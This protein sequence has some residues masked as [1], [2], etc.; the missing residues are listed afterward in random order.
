MELLIAVAS[1]KIDKG[2]LIPADTK[3]QAYSIHDNHSEKYLNAGSHAPCSAAQAL[4]KIKEFTKQ[5][6]GVTVLFDLLE[7]SGRTIRAKR[8]YSMNYGDLIQPYRGTE[9]ILQD[10]MAPT[11]KPTNQAKKVRHI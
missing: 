7:P 6:G 4:K 9:T 10:V 3:I 5:Y 2:N 1:N 8:S 11:P